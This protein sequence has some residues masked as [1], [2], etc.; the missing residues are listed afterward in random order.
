MLPRNPHL[1][2]EMRQRERGRASLEPVVAILPGNPIKDDR[3]ELMGRRGQRGFGNAAQDGA[4]REFHDVSFRL[5]AT[6]DR[7]AYKISFRQRHLPVERTQS[8]R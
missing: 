5:G 1:P 3:R 4:G 8:S 7:E 6:P 2:S